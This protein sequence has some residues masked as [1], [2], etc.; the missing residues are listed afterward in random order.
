M[1]GFRCAG[2]LLRACTTGKT[3]RDARKSARLICARGVVAVLT[4]ALIAGGVP[5]P[6]FAD[7][8][9]VEAVAAAVEPQAGG[10]DAPTDGAPVVDDDPASQG[11]A[12]APQPEDELSS[13]GAGA[14]G[15]EPEPQA[16]DPVSQVDAPAATEED[17]NDEDVPV[18]SQSEGVADPSAG[19]A[20]TAGLIAVTGAVIGRSKDGEVEYWAAESQYEVEIGSTAR[21]FVLEVFETQG[22]DADVWDD[23]EWLEILEVAGPDDPNNVLSGGTDEGWKIFVDGVPSEWG[24][25]VVA[26]GSAVV[27]AYTSKSN[28]TIP[29]IPVKPP[30]EK[31]DVSV[32]VSVIGPDDA[33]DMAHW[34]P[35]TSL[36]LKEGY[37]AAQATERLFKDAGLSADYGV[38]EWGWY[39]TSIRSPYTGEELGWDEATGCFWQL[40][41]NGKSS[42]V[43][44]G[45]VELADNMEI[46]W[47]YSADSSAIPEVSEVPV[48]PDAP[49]PD[50][51][52][53]WPGFG[54]GP[55]P[56]VELPT[57]DIEESWAVKFK[58][59]QDFEIDISDPIYVGD[60]LYMGRGTQLLQIDPKTGETLR[61]GKLVAQVNSIARMVYTD[62]LIIIPLNDGRLQ[63]LTADTL[64]TVWA[65]RALD[66]DLAGRRQQSLT[67]LTLGDGCVYYGTSTAD[68]DKSYGG[69]L[70][71]VDVQTGTV[72]WMQENGQFGFYWAGGALVNGY[73]V[74]G[75]DSRQVRTIDPRTGDTVSWF[76]VGDRV[77]STI[78]PAGDGISVLAVSMDGVLHRLAVA[79]DG[80]LSEVGSVKFAKSSTC[81]PVISG[82]KVI[83]GGQSDE[84]KQVN[85]YVQA[86]YGLLAVIDLSTMDV[87]ESVTTVEGSPMIGEGKFSADIQGTPVVST[88]GGETYVYFTANTRP[89]GVYRYRL[90]TGDV[91]V[92]YI[93]A[94]DA[95]DQGLSS[96]VVGPDGSLYYYNDSGYLFALKGAADG[97]AGAGG[98]GAGD[99]G[100]GNGCAGEGESGTGE[101][102]SPTPLAK[103]PVAR[104][105]VPPAKK[106]VVAEDVDND[107]AL[108]GEPVAT[109]YSDGGAVSDGA[110]RNSE[111][112]PMT[113]SR[114]LPIA[115][116]AAGVVGLVAVGVWF[117]RQRR[118]V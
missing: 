45:S 89:G 2:E 57:G 29:E 14:Q 27:L 34:A 46:V 113:F 40:F 55:A 15:V 100:E 112:E 42:E 7:A 94:E 47:S 58:D 76:A 16:D 95:R 115:G 5:M 74:I 67:T 118:I 43:G 109:L 28:P 66:K 21:Q 61:A 104:G 116:M 8:L 19:A 51:E 12:A 3:R 26:D 30:V 99:S 105:P 63:A 56:D 79:V 52:S 88:Q 48:N 73:L 98:G 1:A 72:L 91:E 38:G 85:Q 78:V 59:K 110:A 81:T 103:K 36:T 75:D 41:V 11:G 39:L 62:G 31:E 107:G 10:E 102:V 71:C 13:N 50:W 24:E 60:C 54:S 92:V 17:A 86:Y 80:S 84:F 93:P 70:Q 69:Y 77:R 23:G 82:N 49:R 65:T 106:P 25:E 9:G 33:G 90:G 114:V 101:G 37:T 20:D 108:E 87:L 97:D 53:P 4:A 22:L 83:V 111:A 117:V 35:A 44:A 68:S 18:V 96:I 32:S 64:T 6:A